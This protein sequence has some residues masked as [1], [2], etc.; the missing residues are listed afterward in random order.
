MIDNN[1][2]NKFSEKLSL[3]VS[4][5]SFL[6]VEIHCNAIFGVHLMRTLIFNS[7]K[8][9]Y[10]LEVLAGGN[11]SVKSIAYR[12]MRELSRISI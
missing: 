9:A 8:F 11:L 7:D 2:L 6:I 3:K 12:F 1:F 4:D 5:R 10:S